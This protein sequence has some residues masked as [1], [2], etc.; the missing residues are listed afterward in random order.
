V[1][2]TPA[3]A[4]RKGHIPICCPNFCAPGAPIR[5]THPLGF[6]L[7]AVKAAPDVVEYHLHAGVSPHASSA[8]A[9]YQLVPVLLLPCDA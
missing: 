3:G 7:R 5:Q 2:R 9:A 4:L 8:R 1:D 6:A